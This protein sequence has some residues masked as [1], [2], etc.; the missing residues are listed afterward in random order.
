ME[1]K[2]DSSENEYLEIPL[3]WDDPNAKLRITHISKNKTVR[4]NKC[5]NNNKIYPGPE[6]DYEH[7]PKLIESLAKIYNDKK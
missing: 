3:G 5:D 6:F 7:V 4:L 2:K 1:Y